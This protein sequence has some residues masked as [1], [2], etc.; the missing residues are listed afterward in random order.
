MGVLE[1]PHR[2]RAIGVLKSRDWSRGIGVAGLESSFSNKNSVDPVGGRQQRVN[3]VSGTDTNDDAI[4]D[5][6][7][8][9]A[10]D[11]GFVLRFPSEMDAMLSAYGWGYHGDSSGHD[12]PVLG[13]DGNP[14]DG[15]AGQ[16]LRTLLPVGDEVLAVIAV[17]A[18]EY[19]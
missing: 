3:L 1:W 12:G 7:Q 14:K 5:S 11:K 16:C 4:L 13:K 9:W 6:D 19:P 15:N 17:R 2:S 8:G 18:N 10:G